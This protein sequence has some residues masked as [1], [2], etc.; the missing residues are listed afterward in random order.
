MLVF[1]III[2]KLKE[3]YIANYIAENNCVYDN[4]DVIL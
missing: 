3:F 4:V 1:K 2:L